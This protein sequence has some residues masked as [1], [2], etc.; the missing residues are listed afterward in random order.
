MTYKKR[1]TAPE[2]RDS[3]H[4]LVIFRNPSFVVGLDAL[5]A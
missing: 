2:T 4:I 1:K 5:I 3:F